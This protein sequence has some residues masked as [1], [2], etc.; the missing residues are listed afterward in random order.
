M[1]GKPVKGMFFGRGGGQEEIVFNF[2]NIF[3]MYHDSLNK[4]LDIPKSLNLYIV[5]SLWKPMINF[6]L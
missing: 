4:S 6:R 3:S 1:V 5:S 2:S